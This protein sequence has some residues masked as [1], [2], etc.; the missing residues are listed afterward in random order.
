ML[1]GEDDQSEARKATWDRLQ[2][3]IT[4]N[5]KPFDANNPGYSIAM[6][7]AYLAF[8]AGVKWAREHED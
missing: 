7:T 4:V 2:K 6:I 8:D 1:E 5:D 3:G